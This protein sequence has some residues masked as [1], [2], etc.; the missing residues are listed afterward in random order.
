MKLIADEHVS[1]KIVRA[2]CEMA[3]SRRT[4]SLE[5]VIGN[6]DF[7]GQD[8]EDW[9]ARF[10]KS[11]GHGLLSA[12]RRMLRRPT[13][14]K[15]I[16]DTGLVAIFLPAEW[17]NSRCAYQA[18]HILYWWPVI[19]SHFQT[20]QKGTAWIVPKGH[21]TGE[22]RQYVGRERSQKAAATG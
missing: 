22:L 12:D 13:L 14:I 1:P 6:G 18:S 8:D 10:A 21:G 17:A 3:L 7:S 4:F 9:V 16:T 5:T 19:E 2:V 20:V 15:Q 11:G